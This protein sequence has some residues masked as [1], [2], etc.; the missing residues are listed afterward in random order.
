MKN[1][2]ITFFICG[3]FAFIAFIFLFLMSLS[4]SGQYGATSLI[5]AAIFSLSIFFVLFDVFIVSAQPL[6]LIFSLYFSIFFSLPAY[7]HSVWYGFPFYGLVYPQQ[8][9]ELSAL[10]S[11][12]C[13]FV[14]YFSYQVSGLVLNKYD[15]KSVVNFRSNNEIS[16]FVCWIFILLSF[17]LASAIGWSR[18]TA[19]RGDLELE[20]HVDLVAITLVRGL[21][22]VALIYSTLW[23]GPLVHKSILLITSCA[24]FLLTNNPLSIPRYL[25]ASYIFTFFLVHSRFSI[26]DRFVFVVLLFV[27]IVSLF[28]MLSEI[29]RKGVAFSELN[30]SI[31]YYAVS[32][33][34]DGFQSVINVIEYARELGYT[35]GNNIASIVFSFVPRAIWPG[36]SPGL[37]SDAAAN[38]GYPFI[39]ISSPLPA[40]LYIDFGLIG[41]LVGSVA[42]GV[43]LRKG[44]IVFHRFNGD[45]Y[46][47]VYLAAWFGFLTII[48]RGPLVGVVAPIAMVFLL[49]YIF[50]KLS[51]YFS[52]KTKNRRFAR[53]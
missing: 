33:D 4:G 53:L 40:E 24:I 30:F 36:K 41:L 11:I 13:V 51:Y 9:A 38:M 49:L 31:D 15:E 52:P 47:K 37:G 42:V 34:F 17:T 10:V 29:S 12:I 22:F 27:G 18:V 5:L 2:Y 25:L 50:R 3:G 45:L 28:P 44:D 48:M 6:R 21:S 35:Y 26:K 19:I 20:S 14:V 43:L 39:N 7:L 23:K 1:K 32:G 16:V 8:S 46:S